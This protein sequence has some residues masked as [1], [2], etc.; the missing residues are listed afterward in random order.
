MKV[1]LHVNVTQGDINKGVPSSECLCP[2]ALAANRAVRQ[3]GL[4]ARLVRVNRVKLMISR[5]APKSLPPEAR[6]FIDEFDY[7]GGRWVKPFGF[8]FDFEM[9]IRKPA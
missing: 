6:R 9:E 8:D 3:A 4:G 7:Y 1:Q 2:I 5:A